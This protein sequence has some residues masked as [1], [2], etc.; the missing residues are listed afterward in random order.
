MEIK[1]L[2]ELDTEQP[3]DC[4]EWCIHPDYPHHF[5]C[6]TYHLED[7]ETDFTKPPTSTICLSLPKLNSI[8]T[9]KCDVICHFRTNRPDI[10]V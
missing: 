9:N 2:H 5:I 1:T 10:F 3:A 7:G 4:L 6:G 8:R